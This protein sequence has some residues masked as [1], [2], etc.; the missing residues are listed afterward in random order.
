[1]V[2][3]E[4]VYLWGDGYG[5][6]HVGEK[7]SLRGNESALRCPFGEISTTHP[8][9]LRVVISLLSSV[10]VDTPSYPLLDSQFITFHSV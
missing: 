4:I 1:M 10:V 7:K 2:G 8:R 3:D 6:R 9:A 5:G